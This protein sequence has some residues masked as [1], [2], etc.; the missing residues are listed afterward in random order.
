VASA[1]I[2]AYAKI[3][4]DESLARRYPAIPFQTLPIPYPNMTAFAT[5][6][7]LKPTWRLALATALALIALDSNAYIDPNAGGLLYQILLPVIVAVVAGWRYLRQM[8][9]LLWQRLTRSDER[10]PSDDHSE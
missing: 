3:D 2:R 7:G 5:R 9:R 1:G 8:A 10:G 6:H 4:A